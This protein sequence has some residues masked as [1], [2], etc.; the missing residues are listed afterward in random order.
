[1]YVSCLLHTGWVIQ[2][3]QDF[4]SHVCLYCKMHVHDSCRLI[5]TSGNID[6]DLCNLSNHM[7]IH[8]YIHSRI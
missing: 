7:Y 2:Y 8:A 1:M 5:F 6:V 4:D 3:N